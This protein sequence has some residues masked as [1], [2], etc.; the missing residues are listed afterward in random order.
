M[1]QQKKGRRNKICDK[2]CKRN[3]IWVDGIVQDEVP[4]NVY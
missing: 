2:N 3:G 1:R 4:Q